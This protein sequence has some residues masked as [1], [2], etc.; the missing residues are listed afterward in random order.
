MKLMI[1]LSILALAAVGAKTLIDRVR[2]RIS[3]ATGAG[4]VVG[5]TLSPAF[6]EAA[7]SV[8]NAST[9]AAH[10][11]AGAT[12]EAAEQLKDAA[13]GTAPAATTPASSPAS[14]RPGEGPL[15]EQPA[16]EHD[17][18]LSEVAARDLGVDEGARN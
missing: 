14:D 9:H 5:E 6:R 12:R 11:V 17:H 1:R 2:P 10:E 16:P 3:G 18:Q 7:N 15:G 4:N 13:T 8:R